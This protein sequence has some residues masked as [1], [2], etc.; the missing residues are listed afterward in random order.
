MWNDATHAEGFIKLFGLPLTAVAQRG[1]ATPANG[2]A[3]AAAASAPETPAA[4]TA[5]R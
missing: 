5:A 1:L 4:E 2:A 3:D